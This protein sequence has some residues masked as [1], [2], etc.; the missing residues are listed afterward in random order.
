MEALQFELADRI[1]FG[2]RFDGGVD[3]SV[4]QDL[5][6]LGQ[7]ARLYKCPGYRLNRNS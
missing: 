7:S 2:Q 5:T 1:E 4:D 6:A 3:F